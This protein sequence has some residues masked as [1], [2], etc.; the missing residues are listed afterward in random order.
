MFVIVSE[1]QFLKVSESHVL[2]LR[3]TAVSLSAL[4]SPSP[5]SEVH[6][7]INTNRVLV[8]WPIP[9]NNGL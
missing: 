8:I 5:G 2:S 7:G 3:G 9:G 4:I 6:R 1:C